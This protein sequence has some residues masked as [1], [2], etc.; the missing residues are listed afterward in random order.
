MAWQADVVVVDA[1]PAVLVSA[2][3]LGTCCNHEAAA[4]PRP[5]VAALA[6]THRLIPVCPEV[7]LDGNATVRTA[8]GVDV[9]A[10]YLRGARQAVE[11]ATASRAGRA[12]LKARSPSCGSARIYDG[13][14]SRTQR[15]GSG[16]TA[17]A[18]RR[19]GVDVVSEDDLVAETAP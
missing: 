17:A 3:L 5:A 11:L 16:V 15:D 12:V 18:L 6:T 2:C 8:E 1:R 10:A 9:T 14:F 13:T 19:A 7:V 4:S